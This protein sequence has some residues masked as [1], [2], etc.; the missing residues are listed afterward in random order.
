M[1]DG[2]AVFHL[3]TSLEHKRAGLQERKEHGLSGQKEA[4]VAVMVL[5]EVV[6]N[7]GEAVG[8]RKVRPQEGQ[9]GDGWASSLFWLRMFS[10]SLSI[11]IKLKVMNRQ[12]KGVFD[13]RQNE[14]KTR[15]SQ[16][17]SEKGGLLLVTR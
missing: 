14:F 7:A 13:R 5:G 15:A 2:A 10:L 6:G 9:P 8:D 16:L 3:V 1:L 11:K 12:T 17:D 4:A